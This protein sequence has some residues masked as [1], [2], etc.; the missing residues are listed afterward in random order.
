MDHQDV[1]VPLAAPAAF[2]QRV[3]RYGIR[4]GIALVIVFESHGF[5]CHGIINDIVRYPDGGAFVQTGTEVRVEVFRCPDGADIGG[6]PGVHRQGIGRYIPDMVLREDLDSAYH[7]CLD[8]WS[9]KQ[10]DEQNRAVVYKGA[11]RHDHY[12]NKGWYG[13]I[14]GMKEVWHPDG[15]SSRYSGS[16]QYA[17]SAHIPYG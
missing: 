17:D 2:D 7:G 15:S 5:L 6:G 12:S 3:G 1:A 8:S 9:S 13:R 4:A 16:R 14:P 10:E 11:C